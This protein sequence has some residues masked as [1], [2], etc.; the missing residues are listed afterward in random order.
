MRARIQLG[1]SPGGS[2]RLERRGPGGGRD[3][4]SGRESAVRTA[5]HRPPEDAEWEDHSCIDCCSFGRFPRDLS[6]L[7]L[8]LQTPEA[9]RL[10]SGIRVCAGACLERGGC[11][12]PPAEL[13]LSP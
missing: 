10:S 4:P 1:T 11:E 12:P 5:W 9:L 8:S 6:F 3:S 2:S 13:L 7:T